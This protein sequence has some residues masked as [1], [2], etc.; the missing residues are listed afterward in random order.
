[1]STNQTLNNEQKY[2]KIKEIGQGA[3]AKVY[4]VENVTN[5]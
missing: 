4:L 3:Y 2:K 5:S 1:M